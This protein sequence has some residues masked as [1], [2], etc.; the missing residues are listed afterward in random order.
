MKPTL[1]QISIYPIK[2]T[3]P[4]HLSRSA[5]TSTGL[6]FDRQFVIC[7]ADGKFI[8]ART[9]P[10]LLRVQV[11]PLQN[12]M[13]I[14]APEA[15]PLALP[16]TSF[17]DQYDSINIWK[18]QIDAVYCGELAEQWFSQLL[19]LP[20]KLYYFG[21]RSTRPVANH[22]ENQIAFADG[23]PLLLTSTASLVDL[24]QRCNST[25]VMDQMRPNLV[26][27]NTVPYAEDSWKRI[28]IGTVE[29]IITKPCGRCILTTTN[30]ETLERNPDREP[31]SVLKQHR[32]GNDGEAHFGQNLIALNHGIISR[33]DTVEILA[34]CKPQVYPAT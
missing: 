5:L 34:T 9:Q 17:E 23:Y 25:V 22:P 29:F 1:S 30:P 14:S 6:A 2:S 33:G 19:G 13:T 16:F 3:A 20:C 24:N 28:K 21:C 18:D 11:A 7:D 8:T 27:E 32:K 10:K 15:S 12:G 31:L 4:L 26:V